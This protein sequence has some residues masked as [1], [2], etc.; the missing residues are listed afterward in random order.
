MATEANCE[1]LFSIAERLLSRGRHNLKEARVDL[2]LFVKG[3]WADHNGR[4]LYRS[5]HEY[6]MQS[7]LSPPSTSS[8]STEPEPVSVDSDPD[9]DSDSGSGS[10]SASDEL[11]D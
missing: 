9:S 11:S 4:D 6:V 7:I 3:N 2:A 1:R 5:V 10:D 8:T